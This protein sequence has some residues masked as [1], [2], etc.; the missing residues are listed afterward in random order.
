MGTDLRGG[1]GTDASF[2]DGFLEV[3]CVQGVR[4]PQDRWYVIPT[5]YNVLPCS[6]SVDMPR[7]VAPLLRSVAVLR[8]T[9]GSESIVTRCS[10]AC[11]P[12]RTGKRETPSKQGTKSVLRN[13]RDPR[14]RE[15]TGVAGKQ[16]IF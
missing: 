13:P 7:I 14:E 4:A 3:V 6:V 8:T 5:S 15:W 2:W 12:L 11:A 16:W 1:P 10:L 9:A